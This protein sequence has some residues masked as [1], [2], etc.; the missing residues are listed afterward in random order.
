[1]E[2]VLFSHA[3]WFVYIDSGVTAGEVRHYYS[4]AGDDAEKILSK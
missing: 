1:M 4:A 3:A 2:K